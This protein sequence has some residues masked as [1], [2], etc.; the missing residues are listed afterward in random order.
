MGP[1]LT[2]AYLQ[3]LPWSGK[4][5]YLA[6][7][8]TVWR[9]HPSDTDAAGYARTVGNFTQVYLCVLL[10]EVNRRGREGQ[11]GGKGREGGG[12]GGRRKSKSCYC[13]HMLDHF[14]YSSLFFLN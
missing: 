4:T 5:D 8:K 6:A 9:I 10:V 13:A 7:E 1:P 14:I 2:E 12:E 3:V 11:G